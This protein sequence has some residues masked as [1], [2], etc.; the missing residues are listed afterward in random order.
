MKVHHFLM[1]FQRKFVHSVLSLTGSWAIW[2]LIMWP[3]LRSRGMY[4]MESFFF[5]MVVGDFLLS[6]VKSA[7]ASVKPSTL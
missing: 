5:V 7:V 3:R 1:S 4:C 2:N 6:E